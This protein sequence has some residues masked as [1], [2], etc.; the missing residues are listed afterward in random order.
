MLISRIIVM[1][2]FIVSGNSGI[3]GNVLWKIMWG[4][5]L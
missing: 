5:R 1:D 4:R 3:S 2:G